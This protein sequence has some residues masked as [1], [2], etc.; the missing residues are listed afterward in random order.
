MQLRAAWYGRLS[1]KDKQDATLSFPTQLAACEEKAK[2][3]GYRV[4]AHYRDQESGR[5]SDREAWGDLIAEARDKTKRRFDA[6]IAYNTAR[7]G[8]DLLNALAAERELTRLGIEIFYAIEAGDPSTPEGVLTRRLFQV[9]DQYEVEKLSRETVRGLRE[10]IRQG[11]SNGGRAPYGYQFESVAHPDWRRARLGDAKYRLAPREPEASVVREVYA[12]Y[13]AGKG[14]GQIANHLNRPGGPPPPSSIN[15]GFNVAKRWPKTTIHNILRNPVY[16]GDLAWN[17]RD[18]SEYARGTGPIRRR[19]QNE[20]IVYKDAH[21]PIIS[22]DD[23]DRVQIEI[24]RR[25]RVE[26]S[27]RRRSDQKA[28]YVYRGHVRCA[29]GHNPLGMHGSTQQNKYVYYRCIYTMNYGAVAAEAIGHKRTEQI[30]EEVIHEAAMDF[31]AREIFGPDR[32]NILHQQHETMKREIDPK[33]AQERKRLD[34]ERNDVERRIAAQIIGIEQ[35]IDPVLIQRRIRELE[36]RRADIDVALAEL[37]ESPQVGDIASA[38]ELLASLPQLGERLREAPPKLLRQTLDAFRVT[39]DID[40]IASTV[41][42]R[43]FVSTALG[44]SQ[45]LEEIGRAALDKPRAK[46]SNSFIAG[47]GFEPATSGL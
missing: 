19:P 40:R 25:R 27:S 30:R 37:D 1:T 41:T 4:V 46:V 35:G 3:L 22:R 34:R 7:L 42:I 39:I 38:C 2:S 16:A 18:H 11:F 14:L 26:G 20:W 44:G 17:K 6:V 21:E 28:F 13:L 47:A 8:R 45:T 5:R 33:Q 29:T 32:L 12:L 36:E 24:T 23:F 31:F 15:P 43:A 9:F 10:N